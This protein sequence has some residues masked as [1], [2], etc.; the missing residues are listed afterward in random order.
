MGKSSGRKKPNTSKIKVD[1]GK[2][3][4]YEQDPQKYYDKCPSWRVTQ[5]QVVDPYGWHQLQGT[6]LLEIREK[7]KDFESRSWS[8]IL[9][10]SKKN[11]HTVEIN[12][13]S[14]EAQNFITQKKLDVD[15][16]TSLP[17]SG[18][19]RIWGIVV[20]GVMDLLFWD[21]SHEVCPSLKKH[22]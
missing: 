18:K 16:L 4:R 15:E 21:P 1:S 5:L 13:L 22:T 19:E 2:N 10:A 17:L 8:E 7:L 12:K 20:D 6:K 11:N 3:P 14:K 9:V